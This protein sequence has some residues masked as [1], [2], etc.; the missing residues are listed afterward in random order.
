MSIV[1]LR[2]NQPQNIFPK[3]AQVGLCALAAFH[4]HYIDDLKAELKPGVK[5]TLPEKTPA[6][7]SVQVAKQC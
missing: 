3:Q 5:L 6:H 1:L 4:P 2:I 7:Y